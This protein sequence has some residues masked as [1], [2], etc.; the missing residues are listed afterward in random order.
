[1]PY[2]GS[3]RVYTTA[4]RDALSGISTSTMIYNST[5][6]KTQIYDGTQEVQRLVIA[7]EIGK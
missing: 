4:Q 3:F 2:T 5:T 6:D 1:M 7:R